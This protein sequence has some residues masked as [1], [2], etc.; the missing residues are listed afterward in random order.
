MKNHAGKRSCGRNILAGSIVLAG[1]FGLL[2]APVFAEVPDTGKRLQKIELRY[3]T[4]WSQRELS[5]S[6]LY[7]TRQN[8]QNV[9]R[10]VGRAFGGFFP[11]QKFDVVLTQEEVFRAYSKSPKH[12]SGLFDGTIHLPIRT[13]GN[14]ARLKAILYHEYTHALLWL[15]SEGK[16]ASWIHEGFAVDQEESVEPRRTIDAAR[17]VPGGRLLWPLTELDARLVPNAEDPM[18][19]ELAYQEAFGVARYLR[20]QHKP[21]KILRWI[22]QMAHSDSWEAAARDVLGAGAADLERDA[23]LFLTGPG[24]G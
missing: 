6:D 4:L 24:R 14:S 10:E 15:A 20:S 5:D 19:N 17:I 23:A 22:R 2:T 11:D 16:C 12:V 9:R 8:L 13:E 18:S 1:V 21:A 3:F 7:E